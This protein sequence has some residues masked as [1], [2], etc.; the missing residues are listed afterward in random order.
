ME[1]EWVSCL[2]FDLS[3]AM[4]IHSSKSL[5]MPLLLSAFSNVLPQV[6][7]GKSIGRECDTHPVSNC[8]GT[9][10]MGI[11]ATWPAQRRI[12]RGNNC[13]FNDCANGSRKANSTTTRRPW[14]TSPIYLR[15]FLGGL[16]LT[17]LPPLRRSEEKRTVSEPLSFGAD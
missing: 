11:F 13:N 6:I 17:W 7:C 12:R 3:L 1:M 9:R 5:E 10:L 16:N 8:R 2:H 15:N 14:S 4:A